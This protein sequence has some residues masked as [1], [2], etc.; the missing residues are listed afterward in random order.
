MFA[1]SKSGKATGSTPPPP[2]TTDPQFPY[3]TALLTGDGTNGA[4]NN[5][6]IDSSTNNFTVTRV[7][8]TTQGSV[9]PY[10]SNWSNYFDGVTAQGS[11]TGPSIGNSDYTIEF[12]VYHT[13]LSGDTDY[14]NIYSGSTI[15][16]LLENDGTGRVRHNL[17]DN[18]GTSNFD[19]NT[20]VALTV[21]TWNHLAFV[22]SGSTAYTF[23]NGVGATASVGGTRNAT[24]T[25]NIFGALFTG[26]RRLNGYLSNL[27]LVKGT[28]LY[29]ANFTPPTAP[30]T[31]ITN[32]ALLTCQSNRFVDNSTNNYAITGI[33]S[34][35]SIQVFSPFSPVNPYNPSVNGGS[36]YFDGAGDWLTTS[37]STA[38]GFAAQNFTIE[39]WV[40]LTAAPVTNSRG[41][42]HINTSVSATVSG[43]GLGFTTSNLIQYYSGGTF[44]TT[45]AT[46]AL[47]QWS[48]IAMV[49]SSGTVTVYLNGISISTVADSQNIST[50]I[51][52][53]GVW[54]SAQTGFEMTGYISNFRVLKGT[55]VYTS[56]FVPPVEPVSAIS[57]TQLLLNGTNGGI[58]DNAMMNDYET[59]GNAQISTAVVKYGTGSMYF[60]GT[61]DWLS[62]PLNNAFGYGTGDWTI[63]FWVYLNS[64]GTQTIVSN[65][66]VTSGVQPHIYYLSGTGIMFYTNSANRITGSALS[67]GVWYH[68]AL[69]KSSGNTKLFVNGTQSGSTYADTN[70]YGTSN[71]LVLANYYSN[72]P[73]FETGSSLNGYIDD[74]RITKYA[75]YV[76]NFTPPTEAFPTY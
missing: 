36:M 38:L 67:T 51:A 75:R 5:T 21:N 23:I 61:G 62:S 52:A 25:T 70:N 27:R 19:F 69:S 4:Q 13:T 42:W 58:I 57:G 74:L 47:K 6:F 55:A 12:W 32:T 31:A 34:S 17:R 73:T 59:V 24:Y 30:L 26:A 44:I 53:L 18:A 9:S 63:E 60:D 76:A 71:P 7:G 11:F 28:A 3:V 64:V 16:I 48:H 35:Q 29:T 45:S 54:Y 49:R 65:L 66:Q 43:Y 72:Y 41:M 1:A 2:A 20:T 50:A 15:N 39:G 46:V 33:T 37:T 68:I 22:V 8:N 40:F 56:N 14:Y 10:G